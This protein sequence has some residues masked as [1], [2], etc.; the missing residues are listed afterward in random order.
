MKY[1]YMGTSIESSNV[2]L[3]TSRLIH[4]WKVYLHKRS[5]RASG[6]EVPDEVTLHGIEHRARPD[7]RGA[8]GATARLL[9]RIAEECYRQLISWA[10]QLRGYVVLYDRHF[11]FDRCPPPAERA[12]R[13]LTDRLHYWFLE[14]VYPRPGLVI[15]LD[16]SPEVMYAR[17]QEVPL[18]RLR[19]DRESLIT[20]AA[21]VD[22]FVRVDAAQPLDRVLANVRQLVEQHCGRE[23][24][25]RRVRKQSAARQ[26][27]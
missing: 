27:M 4:W 13:R 24:G 5:L 10:Y 6:R 19:C 26:V 11:L 3:P 8:L 14:H 16:A 15:F 17:K 23:D 18:D 21:Y 20:K 7:R 12:H 2:A 9:A 22:R 25:K 1:L